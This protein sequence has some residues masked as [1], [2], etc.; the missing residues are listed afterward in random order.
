MRPSNKIRRYLEIAKKEAQ[1]SLFKH[2]HGAILVKS[3]KVIQKAFNSPRFSSFAERFNQKE[4]TT[5]TRHA[6]LCC[7]LGIPKHITTGGT[8]IVVRVSNEGKFRNST[9][10]KMCQDIAQF[11]GIRKIIFTLNEI[12]IGVLLF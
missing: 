3:G 7:V 12:E 4:E 2:K 11:A 9:P 5:G 8:I 1:L 10:C 6:E